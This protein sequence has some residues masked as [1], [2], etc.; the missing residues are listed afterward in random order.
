MSGGAL[1]PG[2]KE[3]RRE[4]DLDDFEVLDIFNILFP[5]KKIMKNLKEHV[6]LHASCM[7]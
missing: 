5:S 4:R 3:G 6:I 7:Y 1:L 2:L